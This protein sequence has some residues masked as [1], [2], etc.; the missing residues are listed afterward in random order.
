VL[1]F[2]DDQRG[3]T[4]W[5]GGAT[6]LLA[7]LSKEMALACVVLVPLLDLLR[8]RQLRWQ[9]YVPLV[10]ATVAYF[11][12]RQQAL[13][14]YMGGMATGASPLQIAAEVIRATGFYV[15][16]AIVP[17][18]LCAYVPSVPTHIG[19]FLVGLLAPAL[20]TGVIVAGWTRKRWPM[21]FLVAWFFATLAPSFTV[22]ARRSAS[23]PLADRYLYVP[24]VASCLLLAWLLVRLG[25]HRRIATRWIIAAFVV[26]SSALGIY[27][28]R[29]A[30]VWAD[31]LS[32]WT[33]VAAKVPADA[34]P[35]REL[36]A[37]LVRRNR[38][39]QAERELRQA[40]ATR[41]YPEGTA[42]AYNDL[43]NLYRR[44]GRYV[45]AEQALEAGIQVRS[46]PA[47]YHNLGMTLMAHLE[48]EQRQGDQAAIVRDIARA[49]HALEEALRLG[50]QGA[51]LAGFPQWEPART[52]ALLGQVLFSLG[53]RAAAREHL[54]TALRLEPSGPVADRTRQYMRRLE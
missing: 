29:Y 2:L 4:A 48:E 50:T 5:L 38:L 22:I 31:D 16:R 12:L 23:A 15:L 32:F 8:T 44:R 49:R 21:A 43:G 11:A 18:R 51:A 20:G 28:A 33:D 10:V 6:F 19:Y 52:H 53:D 17:A 47:L 45:E 14:A 24:S 36:A 3:W 13:G 27:A 34:L 42:M 39:D 26:L 7:L 9:R 37:A 35:H 46:H 1:L 25:E 40:L 41:D 30:L 54:E